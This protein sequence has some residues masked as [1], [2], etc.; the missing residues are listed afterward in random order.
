MFSDK[1]ANATLFCVKIKWGRIKSEMSSWQI[2][3]IQSVLFSSGKLVLS[4]QL[5]YHFKA[6][7]K[8]E[9]QIYLLDKLSWDN[10]RKLI[11]WLF[12]RKFL[13]EDRQPGRHCGLNKRGEDRHSSAVPAV[14]RADWSEAKGAWIKKLSSGEKANR[15]DSAVK[16]IINIFEDVMKWE[17]GNPL[18]S[19]QKNT[20]VFF[21]IGQMQNTG[22]NLMKVCIAVLIN[23]YFSFYSPPSYEFLKIG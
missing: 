17:V 16:L 8:R 1:V 18:V 19:L 23:S 15:L 14:C 6:C 2:M 21:Y 20:V 22:K 7:R 12:H 9:A 11:G 4:N 10:N 13:V 3:R 5:L